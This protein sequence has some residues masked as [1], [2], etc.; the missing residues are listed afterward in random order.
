MG[1]DGVD[2]LAILRGQEEGQAELVG[3]DEGQEKGENLERPAGGMP[4][5]ASHGGR[6]GVRP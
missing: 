3:D 2:V 1:L 4:I 6:R 5:A